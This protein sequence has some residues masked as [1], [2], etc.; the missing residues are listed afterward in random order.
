VLLRQTMTMSLRYE[1]DTI[2]SSLSEISNRISTLVEQGKELPGDIFVELV[3]A[4][5]TVGT[6]LRRLERLNNK[7]T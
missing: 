5:R 4:E 2:T 3:A 6:L 7:L 1:I